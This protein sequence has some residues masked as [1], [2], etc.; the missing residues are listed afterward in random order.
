[1]YGLGA[2]VAKAPDGAPLLQLELR[3]AIQ[4]NLVLNHSLPYTTLSGFR[5]L[6]PNR[7]LSFSIRCI[8]IS[9]VH[10]RCKNVDLQDLVSVHYSIVYQRALTKQLKKS[11]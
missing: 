3:L 11:K 8:G 1:M 9:F 7:D 5:E 6:Q 2:S 4:F 10:K